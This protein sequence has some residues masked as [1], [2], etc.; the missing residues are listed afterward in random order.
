MLSILYL[1]SMFVV[2]YYFMH[3]FV[4]WFN[5]ETL[6]DKV[7]AGVTIPS[8]MFKLPFAWV[9]GSLIVNWLNFILCDLSKTMQTTLLTM[10]LSVGFSL[11]VLVTEYGKRSSST[12]Y[13]SLCNLGRNTRWPEYLFGAIAFAFAAYIIFHTFSETADSLVVSNGVYSDFG[14]HISLIRSFSVGENFP[15]QYPHYPSG[16]ISYHFLFHFM[17]SSLEY[18][19]LPLGWAFNLPSFFSLFGMF[20][21]FYVFSVRLTGLK[22]VAFMAFFFFAFRSSFAFFDFVQNYTIWQLPEAISEINIYIGKTQSENWG[23]WTINN[24]P[25]QRHLSHA[26]TVAMIALLLVLPLVEQRIFLS[27]AEK[28]GSAWRIENIQRPIFI[29][30]FL[31]AIAFW[32]GAALIATLLILAG[33][34]LTSRHRFEYLIIAVIAVVLASM[35]SRWF[36]AAGKE[37]IKATFHFGFLAANGKSVK[38]VA[39]YI[40][41][42]YGILIPLFFVSLFYWRKYALVGLAFFL[43]FVFAF[44]IQPTVDIAVNHKFVVITNLFIG[45]LIA[46]MLIDIWRH[47]NKWLRLLVVPIFGLLT[48]TGVVDIMTFHNMNNGKFNYPKN[49]AVSAWIQ[50]NTPPKAIFLTYMNGINPILYAGRPIYLGWPYFGWSAGYDTVAREAEVNAIYG[51]G[52]E[53]EFRRLLAKTPVQYVVVNEAMRNAQNYVVNEDLISKA[54]PLVFEDPFEDTKIF[55]VPQQ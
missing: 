11:W 6:G 8:W 16:D 36:I 7:H 51:A 48:I 44:T 30:C 15:P 21:V 1:L 28:K 5:F 17:A 22:A 13:E 19:G 14:P 40:I 32:N 43:P 54:L 38:D 39:E 25:N 49:N 45:I 23:M 18:L 52:T 2:G 42:T 12:C 53:A 34:A 41:L 37:P 55:K 33:F 50:K 24:F 26:L 9:L 46:W 47:K 4:P 3:K 20:L 31:G 10:G 29:G 35:Q 27:S